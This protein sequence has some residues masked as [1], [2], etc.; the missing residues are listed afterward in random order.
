MKIEIGKVYEAVREGIDPD[1]TFYD[2]EKVE[3]I[4]K[5][6]LEEGW[7]LVKSLDPETEAHSMAGYGTQIVE[8]FELREVD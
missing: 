7:Y 8:A 5:N 3:V 6:F 4:E 1:H 2:G